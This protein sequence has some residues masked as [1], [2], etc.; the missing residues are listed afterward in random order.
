MTQMLDSRTP[1]DLQSTVLRNAVVEVFGP[2]C[3]E[4]GQISAIFELDGEGYGFFGPLEWIEDLVKKNGGG[5]GDVLAALEKSIREENA[6]IAREAKA[7]NEREQTEQYWAGIKCDILTARLKPQ[8]NPKT[9]K[10]EL[11]LGSTMVESDD[12]PTDPLELVRDADE[13]MQ[14]ELAELEE[15]QAPLSEPI[16]TPP[17]AA[18]PDPAPDKATDDTPHESST[19][20]DTATAP[21]T[22][23]TKPL[24]S[25]PATA[26]SDEAPNIIEATKLRLQLIQH[27][28]IPVPLY[29]KEPPVYGKNNKRKGFK[30]WQTL[31]NVTPEMVEIWAKTW[32]DAVNSGMLTRPTPTLDID[33]TNPEA[34]RDCIDYVREHYEDAGHILSRIGKAPKCAIPFRTNEPFKKIVVNVISSHGREEKIEFLSDGQQVVVAGKHPETHRNYNWHGGEPWTIAREDLPYTREVEAQTLVNTLVDEVLVRLHGYKRAGD[35]VVQL[36]F[37]QKNEVAPEF[38]DLPVENMGEGIETPSWW[39]HLS[40]EQKDAALDHGLE[41]IA[42]NSS[43]LKLRNDNDKWFQLVTSVAR[44]GAPHRGDIF[45]KYAG[46]VPGADSEEELRKKLA[47]C[48]KNPRGITVA[49]FIK[50]A[51]ECGAN[52][53][54]WLETYQSTIA[55]TKVKQRYEPVSRDAPELAKLDV[56]WKARIF[57]GDTDG[58]YQNE[59]AFAVACELVRL[60]LNDEFIARVLMTTSCGVYVQESPPYRLNRTI[61]RAH[62]FNIDPDLEK[63]NSQHA[64]LPIGGKT[65]VITWGDDPDFRGRKTVVRAQGFTDFKNLHSNK[66]KLVMTTSKDEDGKPTTTKKSIPLG[67]W[68][69]GRPRRRQYDDGRRFMPQHEVEVVGSVLNMFEGF[70]IQPRKPDG[71]SGASGCQLFLD[72]GLKIMCS[73][74]EEHWDYLLKREA[75]IA[76]NR[77]RSEIAACY[78]TEEEGSGKGFWCNHLGRLYGS[79]FMQIIKA[80][81]VIGKHN[82][83]LETLIKLCADEALFVGDPRQ[84]NILFSLITEPTVDIEP[85]FI[86]VYPV[87]NYLNIDIISNAKHFLPV[88]RTARRFFVP[89][90][91]ENKVG[92]FDYFDAIDKELKN[93]GYEALL[94]HLLHEVDLRNFNIR[95][96]PKTVGLAEQA[97]LSRKG[98]DGL[99][100]KICSEG[101]VPSP[102]EEWPGF[103]VST[104]AEERKGF[105]FLIDTHP[106]R[107]LRDLGAHKVKRELRKNWNCKS[108]DDARRRDGDKLIRGIKWPQLSEL[109][110]L[111]VSRHGKQEWLN[112]EVTEWQINPPVDPLDYYND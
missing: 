4:T 11:D 17:A 60:E 84:R 24:E 59:L 50:W 21:I 51:R 109:R 61:R 46:V 42:T 58:K 103:S 65:R 30:G 85:K 40:P 82:E 87:K 69:L 67:A 101:C 104:G 12:E 45:V 55:P 88:S 29:G 78:R 80:E 26:K 92:D 64:V 38:R 108:G 72:H 83:H 81:H 100:E 62:E 32:P 35:N 110:E 19:E 90:V 36:N 75:W 9:G 52:F 70:P 94:Y 63:M 93:G 18:E 13:A 27:G 14:R 2:Q 54:P 97:E 76:Q 68:W 107:E 15:R 106:D 3:L 95:K 53:E 111:F 34:V 102:H 96:V 23:H 57:E 112:P 74:N 20:A 47:D 1:Q 73:G 56:A 98:I 91:S 7:E 39:D 105:D 6:A 31:D 66:R 71:R 77:Q 25:D 86:G 16:T 43:L 41:C 79:H 44:S 28:H 33:I 8:L 99:V 22:D 49:T 5:G 89:T 37:P 10:W 48:E